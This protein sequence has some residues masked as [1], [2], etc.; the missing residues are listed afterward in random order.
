[1]RTRDRA[2]DAVAQCEAMNLV[3]R[4]RVYRCAGPSGRC[5]SSVRPAGLHLLHSSSVRLCHSRV[6][7][8]SRSA[9][10]RGA[11][12]IQGR[13]HDRGTPVA[14]VPVAGVPCV[15]GQ[16]GRPGADGPVLVERTAGPSRRCRARACSICTI[17]KPHRERS[18]ANGR[19]AS[20][21]AGRAAD[22][23]T[24]KLG[25]EKWPTDEQEF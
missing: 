2:S 10:C 5:T 16:G 3:C 7:T 24:R 25:Y 21:L 12:T 23:S 1:M 20:G 18:F 6:R 4:L 14:G 9:V 8:V 22:R 19:P 15:P 11:P 13:S 17:Q